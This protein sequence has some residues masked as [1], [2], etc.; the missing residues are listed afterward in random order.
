MHNSAH[1][2]PTHYLD[3]IWAVGLVQTGVWRTGWGIIHKNK[4]IHIQQICKAGTRIVSFFAICHVCYRY[5]HQ[6]RKKSIDKKLLDI[7]I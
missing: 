3:E 6:L 7:L 5:I 4:Q 2:V 1:E